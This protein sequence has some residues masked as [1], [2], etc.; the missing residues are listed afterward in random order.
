MITKS[1]YLEPFVEIANETYVAG[2]NGL[3]SI[4]PSISITY[5]IVYDEHCVVG[6]FFLHTGY[7]R[8]TVVVI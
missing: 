4:V 1:L 6:G 3:V 2:S 7:D 5:V 8:Y